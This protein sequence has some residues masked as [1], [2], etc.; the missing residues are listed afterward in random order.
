MPD[1]DDTTALTQLIAI[2]MVSK[3]VGVITGKLNAFDFV[4]MVYHMGRGVDGFMNTSMTLPIGLG[5]D[6]GARVAAWLSCE[7]QGQG[8][9]RLCRRL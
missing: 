1:S 6:P 4:D 7:V 5:G 3:Q 9:P 8:S 2:Q